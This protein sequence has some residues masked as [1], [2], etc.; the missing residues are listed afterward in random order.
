MI[1]SHLKKI[2]EDICFDS[3]KARKAYIRDLV[4]FFKELIIKDLITNFEPILKHLIDTKPK[5][6]YHF[7]GIYLE[8]ELKK[9][10]K[11]QIGDSFLKVYEDLEKLER[12]KTVS[13]KEILLKNGMET[14]L[15][16]KSLIQD[17]ECLVNKLLEI[18]LKQLKNE[19]IEKT[20]EDVKNGFI[21]ELNEQIE[22]I[23]Q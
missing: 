2:F 18:F 10:I 17:R 16:A 1:E 15:L 3:S 19:P 13:I 23:T 14:T 9:R 5:E 6:E 20:M 8:R 21:S 22:K 7:L 12:D 11:Y 4:C